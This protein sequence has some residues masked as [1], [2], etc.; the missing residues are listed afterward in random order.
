MSTQTQNDRSANAKAERTEYL[1]AYIIFSHWR[2]GLLLVRLKTE[3]E[4]KMA[5][6]LSPL[7]SHRH[8]TPPSRGCGWVGYP[9]PSVRAPLCQEG[10]TTISRAGLFASTPTS[11]SPAGQNPKHGPPSTVLYVSAYARQ[12]ASFQTLHSRLCSF[13]MRFEMGGKNKHF[14]YFF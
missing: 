6:Y 1:D 7:I 9:D 14:H 4:P 11:V 3:L 10:P 5:I 13:E 2:G 12:H 8:P